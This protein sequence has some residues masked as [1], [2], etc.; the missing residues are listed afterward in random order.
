MLG[1]FNMLANVYIEKF[2]DQTSSLPR[3]IIRNFKLIRE[4]DEKYIS[5][6]KMIFRHK[7]KSLFT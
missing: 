6:I 7:P 4:L 3:E 2:L 5:L 1:F